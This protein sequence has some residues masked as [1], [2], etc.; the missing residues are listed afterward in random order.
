MEKRG[1]RKN[2]EKW[3][4]KSSGDFQ[5]GAWGAVYVLTAKRGLWKCFGQSRLSGRD[6]G[7][8]EEG[9]H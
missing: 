6:G 9:A 2:R 1:E 4:E 3:M 8:M 5:H 7:V